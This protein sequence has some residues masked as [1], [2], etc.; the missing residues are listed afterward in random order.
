MSFLSVIGLV[1]KLL[2][3]YRAEIKS[4]VNWIKGLGP[5]KTERLIGEWVAQVQSIPKDAPKEDQIEAAIEAARRANDIFK[6]L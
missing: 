4:L 6:R 2:W 1:L 5:A 3:Q